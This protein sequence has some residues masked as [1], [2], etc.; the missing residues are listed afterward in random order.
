MEIYPQRKLK[1][2]ENFNRTSLTKN[3]FFLLFSIGFQI[4]V[5]KHQIPNMLI[6]HNN[7]EHFLS[8]DHFL[9]FQYMGRVKREFQSTKAKGHKET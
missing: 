9:V 5:A 4:S 2:L 8:Y 1:N 6:A 3:F 7:G